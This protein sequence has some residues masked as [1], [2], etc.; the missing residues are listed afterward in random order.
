MQLR[1]IF[2]AAA[3]ACGLFALAACSTAPAPPPLIPRPA[4]FTPLGLG[5]AYLSGDV[6]GGHKAR[7]AKLRAAKIKPLS[8]N[9]AAQYLVS[10]EN[11][12]RA[13]TAGIGLDVL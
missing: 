9:G 11:E 2:S 3:L 6:I 5:A 13:Q 8:A 7:A 4:E 10:T 1:H 12:L